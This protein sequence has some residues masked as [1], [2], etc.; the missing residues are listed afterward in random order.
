MCNLRGSLKYKVVDQKPD[1]LLIT[2]YVYIKAIE[3]RMKLIISLVKKT[4]KLRQMSECL[5]VALEEIDILE[6]NGDDD[7][8]YQRCV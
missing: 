4:L 5:T 6:V 1:I 2:Q 3:T 7:D 8:C